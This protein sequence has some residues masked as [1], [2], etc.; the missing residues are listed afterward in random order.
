MSFI[1]S[2]LAG[3][4]VLVLGLSACADRPFITSSNSINQLRNTCLLEAEQLTKPAIVYSNQ[5]NP[6]FETITL[7]PG[8]FIYRCEKQ[9]NWMIIMYPR[10]GEKIDC[11]YR[12]IENLCPVGWVKNN[13][14]TITTD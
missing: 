5:R 1:K 11:S 2:I 10:S 9:A 6:R 12:N 4:G 7:K 8:H 14:E 3:I 13:L